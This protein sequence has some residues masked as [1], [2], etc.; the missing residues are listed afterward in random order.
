MQTSFFCELRRFLNGILPQ[1]RSV[2]P[3]VQLDSLQSLP[4]LMLS[5]SSSETLLAAVINSS[6]PTIFSFSSWASKFPARQEQLALSP[7]LLEELG[8]RLEQSE[9]QIMELKGEEKVADSA[10]ERLSRLKELSGF[11]RNEPVAGDKKTLIKREMLSAFKYHLS[12]LT[13]VVNCF[14]LVFSTG[15]NQY[16]ALLLLKALQTVASTYDVQRRLRATR[17]GPN[18]PSRPRI[19]GLRS[20]T[21]SFEN[22][23]LGPLRADI[24]NCRGSCLFP[25]TNGNNHAVL[26]NSHT[27]RTNVDERAPCCVPL[28]YD[29]LEVLDWNAEGSFLSVKPDM[30]AKECGCR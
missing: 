1:G 11:K 15:E 10:I 7:A 20:L 14:L 8:Q 18:S 29:P 27:E 16:C 12:P 25:L 24:H 26:L 17:A 21:V 13:S 30:I 5:L 6:T 19:C 9:M 3:A 2:S 4:P 22:L 23:F 28:A